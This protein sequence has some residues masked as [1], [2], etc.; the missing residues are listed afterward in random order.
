M[1][2]VTVDILMFV[3]II[4]EFASLPILVHEIVGIGLLF[5]VIAH[6]KLNW[7]YFKAIPKGKYN[8]KRTLDLIVNVGLTASLVVTIVSGI[9]SSRKSWK[10]MMIGNFRITHI[11]KTS[12]V[13]S[14]VFLGLH[15]FSNRKK[16]L[17]QVKK[18]S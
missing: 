16:F 10:N 17:R 4:L 18:L 13:I 5:L 14:L 1:K 15:L 9:L 8:L 7:N 11:H 2:K 3:A 12:S 6:I